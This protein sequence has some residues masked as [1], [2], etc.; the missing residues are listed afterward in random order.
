MHMQE[1]GGLRL[2]FVRIYPGPFGRYEGRGMDHGIYMNQETIAVWRIHVRS[3]LCLKL[4]E[5][6]HQD[7][8]LLQSKTVHP[9]LNVRSFL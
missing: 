6:I 2:L 9:T 3:E 8:D 4:D 7:N 5:Q 1:E